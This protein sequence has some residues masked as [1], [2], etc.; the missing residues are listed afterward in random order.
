MTVTVNEKPETGEATVRMQSS[1]KDVGVSY[2]TDRTPG[3]PHAPKYFIFNEFEH[4]EMNDRSYEEE[5][6]IREATRAIKTVMKLFDVDSRRGHM[7]NRLVKQAAYNSPADSKSIGTDLGMLR[8][9][10]AIEAQVKAVDHADAR[11]QTVSQ[12]I[13]QRTKK[14]EKVPNFAVISSNDSGDWKSLARVLAIQLK[15][16]LNHME[17]REKESRYEKQKIQEEMMLMEQQQMMNTDD[18]NYD[19]AFDDDYDDDNDDDEM[20]DGEKR[21]QSVLNPAERNSSENVVINKN[22]NDKQPT[23][24]KSAKKIDESKL[25]NRSVQKLLKLEMLQKLRGELQILS[26]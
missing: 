5:A 16:V 7:R 20:L 6:K 22:F 10:S 12:Q 19:D 24:V 2:L 18:D 1:P 23:N 14:N 13:E 4:D 9:Q 17:H 25:V 15:R 21:R 3:R 26:S 8:N 11:A